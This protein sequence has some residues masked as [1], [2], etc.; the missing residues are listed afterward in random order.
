MI[1]CDVKAG[2]FCTVMRLAL[3]QGGLLRNVAAPGGLVIDWVAAGP[4]RPYPAPSCCPWCGAKIR[5]P[6]GR[7]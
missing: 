7:R 2:R 6:A 1:R 3:L 4:R 5:L